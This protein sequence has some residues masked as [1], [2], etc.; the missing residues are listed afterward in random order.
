MAEWYWRRNPAEKIGPRST[1]EVRAAL[2]VGL[3]TPEHEVW[4]EGWDSWARISDVED[5][6]GVGA[7]SPG[8]A[9][10]SPA[11][12][13]GIPD[14]L[15]GWMTFVGVL[16][17]VGGLLALLTCIG[18]IKGIL[19][20]V[21]GFAVLGARSALE[22]AGGRVSAELWPFLSKLKTYFVAQGLALL[23]GFVLGVLLMVL[24]SLG[25]LGAGFGRFWHF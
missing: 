5:F 21:M 18:V 23:L 7:P 6:R 1:E 24:W 2:V 16:E 3:L 20:F 12:P 9:P 11:A 4:Q 25:L 10:A 13:G 14:G 19:L 22:A 15:L 17:I 8:V